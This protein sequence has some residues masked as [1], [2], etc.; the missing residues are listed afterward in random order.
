MLNNG[1]VWW[2]ITSAINTN[3]CIFL[4]FSSFKG[5]WGVGGKQQAVYIYC[6]YI[7]QIQTTHK[8]I[9][10]PINYLWFFHR[11]S[12]FRC[13]VTHSNSFTINFNIA[14]FFLVS[15][16]NNFM[17]KT[18]VVLILITSF[19]FFQPFGGN[20]VGLTLENQSSPRLFTACSS[21]SIFQPLVFS[22]QR[23]CQFWEE[24]NTNEI[25]NLKKFNVGIGNDVS[26]ISKACCLFSILMILFYSL[27]S[28]SSETSCGL[29]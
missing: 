19:C 29:L 17:T 28:T 25:V 26:I 24:Y 23:S 20:L 11:D 27:H 3:I 22:R 8:R 16:K 12:T 9:P 1:C 10:S 7:E 21:N 6:S 2:I 18:V 4:C 14:I 13:K 15:L 5:G